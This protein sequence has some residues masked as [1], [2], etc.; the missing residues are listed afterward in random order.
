MMQEAATVVV[1]L[2]LPKGVPTARR[3][4]TLDGTTRRLPV[5]PSLQ[6]ASEVEEALRRKVGPYPI[7]TIKAVQGNLPVK[8]GDVFTAR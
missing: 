4:A 8:E 2:T 7:I 6:S 5:D 1:A 3:P